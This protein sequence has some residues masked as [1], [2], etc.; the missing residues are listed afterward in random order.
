MGRNEAKARM[1]AKFGGGGGRMG[2]GGIDMDTIVS[3]F[4][5]GFS[6]LGSLGRSGI[7]TASSVL[8][9]QK[10]MNEFTGS[11]RTGGMSLWN[12]ISSAASDIATHDRLFR[13]LLLL[14]LLQ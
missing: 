5:S 3:G 11:V 10:S 8:Q 12:T 9:D 7:E 4:C 14:F 1:A 2:G 6:T 13:I